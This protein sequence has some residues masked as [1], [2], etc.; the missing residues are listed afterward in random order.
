MSDDLLST[1]VNTGGSD[2]AIAVVRPHDANPGASLDGARSDSLPSLG[3]AGTRCRVDRD[4][5]AT[6]RFSHDRIAIHARHSQRLALALCPPH[7]RPAGHRL[8]GTDIS[9]YAS[10]RLSIVGALREN[11]RLGASGASSR[12]GSGLSSAVRRT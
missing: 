4:R 7:S 1:D 11:E 10:Q 8:R 12:K 2:A 6:G 9:L 3:V 5:T